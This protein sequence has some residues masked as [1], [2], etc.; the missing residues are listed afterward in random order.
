MPEE[1][2]IGNYKIKVSR[3]IEKE[4]ELMNI[5]VEV[6]D[7]LKELLNKFAV[8]GSTIKVAGYSEISRQKVKAILTNSLNW[9]NAFN[10]FF[11]KDMLEGGKI[12]IA[13][14]NYNYYMDFV[15]YL[16]EVKE[17]VKLME[18]ISREETLNVTY[19]VKNA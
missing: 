2:V 5:N 16:R 8:E 15:N 12:T 9:K 14:N 17:L 10:Y 7:S 18:E 4:S 19:Q 11:T 6:C 3:H 13:V 1:K